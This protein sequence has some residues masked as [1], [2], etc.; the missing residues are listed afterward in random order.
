[1][2]KETLEE[3]AEKEAYNS[4]EEHKEFPSI[5][6]F[7]R[8]SKYGAKWMQ[9]RMYSEEEVKRLAFDFYYDMSHKMG[10]AE[11][12][13]SENATNVDVWFNEQFKKK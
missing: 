1:M 2:N 8:G 12:L 7:I 5:K 11:N 10:V 4:I 9:D 6:A 3:A 13:I